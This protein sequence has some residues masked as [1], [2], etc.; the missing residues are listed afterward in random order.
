MYTRCTYRGCPA[1]KGCTDSP[2]SADRRVCLCRPG[3][4]GGH[5]QLAGWCRRCL[6][7]LYSTHLCSTTCHSIARGCIPSGGVFAVVFCAAA[8]DVA[9]LAAARRLC[10]ASQPLYSHVFVPLSQ[11]PGGDIL[12]LHRTT[13]CQ[14]FE[15]LFARTFRKPL[16]QL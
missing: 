7:R 6:P 4:S 2:E 13:D 14:Y 3:D 1:V 5:R 10:S 12:T 11:Q 8:S 9:Q 15:V 16:T